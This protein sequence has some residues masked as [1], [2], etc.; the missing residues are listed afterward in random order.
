M[1]V[2]TD[3]IRRAQVMARYKMNDLLDLSDAPCRCGSP[4]QAVR[5][6]EGRRDDVFE[7]RAADG[8]FRL[9]TPDI[10]RNA[11]VDADPRIQDYRIL[12]TGPGTIE[13]HLPEVLKGAADGAVRDALTKAAGRMGVTPV[14]TVR[15]GIATP[16]DR[17]LRRVMRVWKPD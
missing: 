4:L 15:A 9:V 8:S 7:L 13:V 3:F 10:L 17:K 5:R 11:V 6:I 12:Q 14:V 16:Y 2:V 1:P